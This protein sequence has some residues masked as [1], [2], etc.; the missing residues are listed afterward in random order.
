MASGENDEEPVLLESLGPVPGS[1]SWASRR[2][3]ATM[4][5][6]PPSR[7][8]S[9][10]LVC[11]VITHRYDHG[12]S[13]PRI[14]VFGTRRA[15]TS[16]GL[17]VLGQVLHGAR[18]HVG[19]ALQNA[20]SLDTDPDVPFD[21]RR[22]PGQVLLHPPTPVDLGDDCGGIELEVSRIDYLWEE[23]ARRPFAVG[24]HVSEPNHLPRV[25]AASGDA[26]GGAAAGDSEA[27]SVAFTCSLL[28]RA[29]LGK[30][31]LDIGSPATHGTR[32]DLECDAG[33]RGVAPGS[34]ELR[35]ILPTAPEWLPHPPSLVSEE[36]AG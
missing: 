27:G 12:F 10:E 21:A 15:L 29:R 31:L 14:D 28:G 26:E 13:I 24:G 36:D 30:L 33:V 1:D 5:Q 9:R 18:H 34:H 32:F 17:V 4:L 19:I 11:E 35:F 3:D 8:V 23:R 20:G 2:L 7:L 16:L 25:T 6:P 22:I